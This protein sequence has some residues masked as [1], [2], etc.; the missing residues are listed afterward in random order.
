MQARAYLLSGT[1]DDLRSLLLPVIISLIC[2]MIFFSLIV[3][4]P[5]RLPGRRMSQ[6]VVSVNLVALS[7]IQRPTDLKKPT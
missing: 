4:A 5:G 1:E 2:H 6:R 7:Q 3:Y